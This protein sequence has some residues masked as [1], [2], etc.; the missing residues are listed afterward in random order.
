M[1]RVS[2]LGLVVGSSL[3]LSFAA[4]LARDAR[5]T[6]PLPERAERLN[7]YGRSAA[8]ADDSTAMVL[9]P[10]NL[11]Y[12]PSWELRYDGVRCPDTAKVNCGH[13]LAA[14]TPLWFGLTTG[15]RVDYLMPA[16]GAGPVYG[17][18]DYAWLTWALAYRLGPAFSVGASLQRSFSANPITDAMLTASLG[19]S[20][21]PDPHLA[22]SVVLRDF[23]RATVAPLPNGQPVLD[24]SYVAAAAFRPTGK[25]ALELSLDVKYL[26]GTSVAGSGQLVPRASLG[27]DVPY[28]GRLRGDVE[29][30]NV[31]NDATRAI[32]GSVGMEVAFGHA[33]LGGGAIFGS[34]LGN[35]SNQEEVGE[36]LSLA[37]SG[38]RRPGLPMPTHAVSMR[39]ESTPG[40]RGHVA[41]LR[42]LWKIAEDPQISGLELVLR[43]EPAA[44]YAHAE[45]L[46][47]AIRL[48]RAR[49][50]KVLCSFEDNGAK[51]LY[52]CANADRIVINPAG[53]VRYSGIKS[54]YIY[55]AGLLDKL[56]IKA[57]FVRIG[58]HKSAPE[59]FTN[60][61]ASDVARADH[62]D[63][64]REVEAVFVRN[65]SVGR[66]LSEAKVRENSLRGPFVAAE[67]KDA[68][69]VDGFAFDDEVDRAM[70]E[71]VGKETPVVR[72]EDETSE[73]KA[74]GPQ[75][76]VA[77]LYVDGDMI[78]GRSQTVPLIDM[79]FVG[80]YSI[81]ET[82]K[83]MRED[84]S[85]KSVVLRI[86]SP[87]GSSMA[88]DVMWRELRLLA[89]K[90]PLIVSMGSV[91]ASGGYYIASAG[92]EIYA[93]PLTVTGSIG[94]FYGKADISGLLGK[95]GVTTETYKTTPRADA[96]SFFRGFTPDER[97]ELEHKV[98]QFYDVFLDRVAQGR[99]M[100][101]SEVDAV[102][103]GRV[104]TGQ[105]AI[106][107][108]LVDKLGGLREAIAEAR[109]LGGL[110]SDSPIEELPVVDQSLLEQVLGIGGVSGA[111]AGAGLPMQL[112][113]AAR[114]LAPM[115]VYAKDTPLARLEWAPT[116]DE[117]GKD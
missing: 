41:F 14:A 92:K 51:S 103:Q 61:Q 24:R 20:F 33:A 56:G 99:G 70:R 96:E 82:I 97:Q 81:A 10:A 74:F 55:L 83:G 110:P 22:F 46:A 66:K 31:Q 59:Q 12:L 6:E 100:T 114:A 32:V 25:R 16:A 98:G 43:A 17:G 101:K 84:S 79:K 115:V 23:T 42:K 27:I 107:H 4:T 13:A 58:A 57:E 63:L 35:S 69:F 49:G 86:E 47:D 30:N 1:R 104:W 77:L 91:A 116:E 44:S 112:K 65:A 72:Y 21:R 39:L 71:L 102:G 11:G 106:E 26:E 73:P 50:K 90:K 68:G 28:V 48:L 38:Y 40:T 8:S 29:V 109:K 94:I 34:G 64:I 45:E 113:D 9:N 36:F 15:L 67:A 95:L 88:A 75:D 108:K 54:T 80:S 5:A 19:A 89:Q 18:I 105:E 85:V 7:A 3:S 76:R 117:S 111:L 2:L 62:E 93:L 52:V 78:D 60:T 53:G 37:Y 87:G